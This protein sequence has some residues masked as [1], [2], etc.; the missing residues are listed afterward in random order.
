VIFLHRARSI[1]PFAADSDGARAATLARLGA[2]LFESDAGKQNSNWCTVACSL[3]LLGNYLASHNHRLG[4][5]CVRA[6]LDERRRRR[7]RQQRCDEPDG[8]RRRG[9]GARGQ[10]QQGARQHGHR[11][12]RCTSPQ[13]AVTCSAT[14]VMLQHHGNPLLS[15][16]IRVVHETVCG[17]HQ[18]L[19]PVCS[20]YGE[21]APM[22]VVDGSSHG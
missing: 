8:R 22:C 18:L 5:C 1:Q 11:Q 3:I 2:Q 21:P 19:M 12:Q 10:P 20:M 6:P 14:P 17:W 16:G 7:V 4:R 9:R 13:H 15:R